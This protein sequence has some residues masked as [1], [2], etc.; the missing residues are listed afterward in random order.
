MLDLTGCSPSARAMD[1]R[2]LTWERYGF[3]SAVPPCTSLPTTTPSTNVPYAH[4]RGIVSG[5]RDGRIFINGAF[6]V[7]YVQDGLLL[8]DG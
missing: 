1:G 8:D 2:V 6:E 5:M 4:T 7:L 3:R